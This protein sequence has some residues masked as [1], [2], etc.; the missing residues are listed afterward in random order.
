MDITN[1]LMYKF[2]NC[3]KKKKI[4]KRSNVSHT[5][6]VLLELKSMGE[7]CFLG[8]L[9]FFKISLLNI[10]TK[11]FSKISLV[12]SF[13]KKKKNSKLTP[14]MYKLHLNLLYS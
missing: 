7:T 10:P 8:I 9:F 11:S 2:V 1:W 13:L 14:Q 3:K 5:F 12:S 6:K 4:N